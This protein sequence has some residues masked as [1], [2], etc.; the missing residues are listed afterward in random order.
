[1]ADAV[2]YSVLDIPEFQRIIFYPRPDRTP[3]PPGATDHS[4]PIGGGVA[5]SGRFYPAPAG[6]AT[7]LYFHGNG[8]VAPDYDD[9]SLLY[10]Q[11]GISLF[12]A[13][14]RGY[15]R[16]S[17]VPSFATMVADAHHVF[18]Y[19]QQM[20]AGQGGGHALFVMGRSLG[21][22]SAVE[23]AA[24]YPQHLRGLILESGFAH[25]PR[26]L[27]H[28]GVFTMSPQLDA[29]ERAM[30]ARVKAIA[31]PVLVICGD[32]DTLVPP[33]F[34]TSFYQNVGSQDRTLLTIEGAGHNDLLFVG[35]N[36][37]FSAI[38]V[39]VDRLAGAGQGTSQSR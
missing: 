15:G 36:E 25:V 27:R 3:P 32:C 30:E 29:F 38:R 20:V 4:I 6:T 18:R 5:V 37:Y 9:I 11:V 34:A 39:F 21:S 24:T 13:D 22:H 17:G 2:D 8:E 35:L 16:S 31:L 14:Y 7:L 19:V 10:R 1:M 28:H 26:L 12:V 23:L 33:E